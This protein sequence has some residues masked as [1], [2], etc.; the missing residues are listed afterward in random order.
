MADDSKLEPTKAPEVR[1][2]RFTKKQ[3]MS[4]SAPERELLIRIGLVMNDLNLLMRL[5]IT[6]GSSEPKSEAATSA[7]EAHNAILFLL[8]VGKIYEGSAVFK[9]WFLSSVIGRD[10]PPLMSEEG[11]AAVEKLRALQ[12]TSGIL[13]TIRNSFAFHYHDAALSTYLD[14]MPDD[15]ELIHLISNLAGNDVRSYAVQPFTAS[16]L[17]AMGARTSPETVDANNRIVTDTVQAFAMFAAGVE[18]VAYKKMFPGSLPEM[19]ECP[20]DPSDYMAGA[21]VRLPVFVAQPG[22]S[23]RFQPPNSDQ[24]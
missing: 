8:L 11:R 9:K 12:G 15:Q 16:L 4:L 1:A 21:D 3:L 18:V 17:A 10:Y 5:W 2:V 19:Q 20:L 7:N 13:A 14:A 24:S 6:V 22:P 23:R